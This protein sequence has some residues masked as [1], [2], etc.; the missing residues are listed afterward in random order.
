[1]ADWLGLL[2]WFEGS[3]LGNAVRGAGVWAY[4][5]IN[6]A[7][8]LGIATLF[9]AVL[10]L[11]L[12][13]LG[14]RREVNL[15]TLATLTVPVA[16]TGFILA[17]VSGTCLLAT[18]ATDYAGNP[19]L[20]IKFAAIGFALINVL[21]AAR[22]PAW[23]SRAQREAGGRERVQLAT[24]GAVSLTSWLTAIVAGRMIGYW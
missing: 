8:I 19:F 4:A 15:A 2:E 9:G 23:R 10:V 20:L 14:W 1:M 3:A 12:R 5:F 13:L 16:A 24:L 17:L 22:L 6:L 7:H 11:D 18:N 21:V